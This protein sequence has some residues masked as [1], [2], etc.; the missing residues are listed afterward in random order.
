MSNAEQR[1]A[2]VT[3]SGSGIGRQ[4]AIDLAR[5]GY[6]VILNSRSA[7]PAVTA[8]GA[9]E[10]RQ[11]IIGAG[12]QADVV[13][14]D[15]GSPEGRQA[16]LDWIDSEAGRLD[17]LVNNAG[18]AP[19]E[20][21]DILEASEEEFERVIR[22][23]VRGPYFLTQQIARRMIHWRGEGRVAQP[24]IAFVTSISAYTTS[25]SRGE[26]CV[27]KAGLSM[28]AKLFADR[29]AGEGIPVIEIRPGVIDTPMI[30]PVRAQYEQ[31]AR[32]GL[33]PARRL[34]QP[35]DVSRVV[36]AFAR[37]DLDYSTGSAIEVSGGFNLHRL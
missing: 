17:L 19:A 31:R 6:R 29:L 21:R 28:A 2:L 25:T 35:S 5:E 30:A 16:I 1:V 27:A 34:G 3:G 20:R 33:I 8:S 23:N 22:I 10:V 12:G 18:V 32:E 11:A 36:C 26:Y 13:R 37:G 15:V 4:V 24:R 14:A 9:Y 7:D